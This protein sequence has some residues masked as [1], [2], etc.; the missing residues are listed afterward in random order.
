MSRCW[1]E[2]KI[3]SSAII[4]RTKFKDSFFCLDWDCMC[5]YNIGIK[6]SAATEH[7]TNHDITTSQWLMKWRN[8]FQVIKNV[9]KS[10]QV[11]IHQK[12]N[13]QRWKVW[14]RKVWEPRGSRASRRSKGARRT[15]SLGTEKWR[16]E[17]RWFT[18]RWRPMCWWGASSEGSSKAL[19]ALQAALRGEKTN[20][21]TMTLVRCI[22]F[23]TNSPKPNQTLNTNSTDHAILKR[24]VS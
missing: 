7:K 11:R 22:K 5:M 4:G 2:H 9:I 15:K 16:K 1:T 10:I 19:G 14:R 6:I 3:S 20:L 23:N 13:N 12:L 24:D 18:R 21:K 17:A 8:S